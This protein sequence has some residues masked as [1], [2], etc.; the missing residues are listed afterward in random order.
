M[1][2]FRSIL[3]RDTAKRDKIHQDLYCVITILRATE[4]AVKENMEL[5]LDRSF[6]GRKIR[7]ILFSRSCI[8]LLPCD[9]WPVIFSSRIFQLLFCGLSFSGARNAVVPP[10][11]CWCSFHTIVWRAATVIMQGANVDEWS[12][13]RNSLSSSCFHVGRFGGRPTRRAKDRPQSHAAPGLV[14]EYSVIAGD[15]HV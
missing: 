15:R 8:F 5:M 4:N 11:C 10:R 6:Y 12:R 9:V 1:Y 13:Q 3:C 7:P 14:V 2:R